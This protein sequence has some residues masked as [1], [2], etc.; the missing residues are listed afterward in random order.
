MRKAVESDVLNI[1]KLFE[2][3]YK[4]ILKFYFQV[5]VSNGILIIHMKLQKK[6]NLKINDYLNIFNGSGL[7]RGATIVVKSVVS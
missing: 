6:K 7:S 2:T 5:M 1:K 3:E 4:C